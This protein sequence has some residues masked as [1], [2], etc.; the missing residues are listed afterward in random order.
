MKYK[1]IKPIICSNILKYF[2]KNK[3]L[4]IVK[5]SKKFQNYDKLSIYDYNLYYTI[6]GI[7]KNKKEKKIIHS[8]FL[9]YFIENYK[10]IEFKRIIY[11]Y[12][13]IIDKYFKKIFLFTNKDEKYFEI[14]YNNK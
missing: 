12:L 10:E 2:S 11:Y 13:E 14:F 9:N 6:N 5:Y 7:I 4:N 1:N 3:S 8:V